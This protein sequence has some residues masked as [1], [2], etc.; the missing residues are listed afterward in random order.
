MRAVADHRGQRADATD[1]LYLIDRVPTLL[2]WGR[3]DHIIPLSHGE[4]AHARMPGSRLEI[5]EAAGHCPHLDEPDRFAVV[6]G[7]FVRRPVAA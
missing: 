4:R 6:V 5:F 3:H 2:V 7:E 1:R